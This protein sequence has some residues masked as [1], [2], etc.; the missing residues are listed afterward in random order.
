MNDLL[1]R[2]IAVLNEA[3]PTARTSTYQRG[4]VVL[5]D[6]EQAIAHQ[7]RN[8]FQIGD[9][10]RKAKGA[11]WSGKVVGTYSTSLNPEGY[12]VESDA[13]PGSVQIYPASMLELA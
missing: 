5:R 1:A 4:C 7:R 6:L 2:A 12:C 9:T 8:H 10:V 13:H 11:A 3:L